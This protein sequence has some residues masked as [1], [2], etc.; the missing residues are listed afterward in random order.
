[1]PTTQLVLI[2]GAFLWEVSGLGIT[3]THQ[4]RAQAQLLWHCQAVA[5][6]YTGPAPVVRP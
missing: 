3:V 4:Q 5:K 1:M 2:S 6:G